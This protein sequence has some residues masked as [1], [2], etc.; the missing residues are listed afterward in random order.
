MS[1]SRSLVNF[2]EDKY[3]QLVKYSLKMNYGGSGIVAH[4]Y[5]PSYLGGRD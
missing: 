4:I 5:V 3:K 2:K 1:N